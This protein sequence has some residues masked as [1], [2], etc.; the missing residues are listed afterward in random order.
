MRKRGYQLLLT[1]VMVVPIG[2][3]PAT[4]N[5]PDTSARAVG[6][7]FFEA[8]L[9]KDWQSAY[10]ALCFESQGRCTKEEF[11][12]RAEQYR[13]SLGFEPESVHRRSSEEHGNEAI[14]HVAFTSARSSGRH[15]FKDAVTLQRGST[16]WGVVL[17]PSF[18]RRS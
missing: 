17:P 18:G 6:L 5:G 3:G 4:E 15:F 8:L 10:E 14:I 2:C 1:L 7:R 11:A 13:K 12:R 9:D 16:S